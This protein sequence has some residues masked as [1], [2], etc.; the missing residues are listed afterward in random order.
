MIDEKYIELINKEIDGLN[1]QEESADLHRYLKENPDA[2]QFCDEM[3][4]TAQLLNEVDEI[5]PSANLKKNILNSIDPKLYRT[6]IKESISKSSI[7]DIF[8]KPKP[9]LAYVFTLGLV[10]GLLIYSIF[11]TNLHQQ[12]MD[13]DDLY[14]TIGINE[15]VNVNKLQSI[16]IESSE[17]NGLIN[18]NR[19]ENVFFF[20]VVLVSSNEYE[21]LF[22]FE[23]QM[24]DFHTFTPLDNKKYTIDNSDNHFQVSCSGQNKF[25]VFFRSFSENGVNINIKLTLSGKMLLSKEVSLTKNNI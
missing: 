1:T 13:E 14:G 10:A 21:L 2:Y 20:E 15:N 9:R 8:L 19:I 3:V 5:D 17:L 4:Q 7:F 22:E 23:P 16:P 24:I 25:S 6:K 18:L 12:T 11:F